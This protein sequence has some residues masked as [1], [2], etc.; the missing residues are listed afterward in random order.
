MQSPSARKVW[1]EMYNHD[2]DGQYGQISHDERNEQH[3]FGGAVRN[4]S[5]CGSST[6]RMQSGSCSSQKRSKRHQGSIRKCESVFGRHQHDERTRFWYQ[7]HARSGHG[8]SVEHRSIGS[9][10]SQFSTENPLSIESD[11]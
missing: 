11:D 1:I 2:N 3:R 9:G 5:A 10:S 4:E 6:K 7:C 8:R